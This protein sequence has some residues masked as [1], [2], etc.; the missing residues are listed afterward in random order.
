[1]TGR[2]ADRRRAGNRR[3]TI[4]LILLLILGAIFFC[5][6][7]GLLA[8]KAHDLRWKQQPND[9]YC[10]PACGYMLL[11]Y[12]GADYSVW[13]EPLT[14]EAVADYMQTDDYGYTSF[15]DR[16]FATAINEWLGRDLYQTIYNPSYEE[17]RS[18]VMAS[19][20]HGYP[21]VIDSQEREGG[22]HLNHHNDADFTHIMIIYSYNPVTDEVGLV[23]PL[24]G[25]WPDSAAFFHY[26][27]LRALVELFLQEESEDGLE[28]VGIFC[29]Y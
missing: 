3:R 4:F 12:L 2:R 28:H 27:S 9:Y 24:A 1:M 25:L 19:F 20:D 22:D 14:I 16:R 7:P 18:A 15:Q 8:G 13:G 26:P 29:A 6:L 10:G 23:D 11:D 5:S 17:V 21:V